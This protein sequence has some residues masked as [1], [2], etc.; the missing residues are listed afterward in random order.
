VAKTFEKVIA[1]A[2]ERVF[3][4]CSS[5]SSELDGYFPTLDWL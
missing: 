3:G 1:E 2:R 4:I 5:E